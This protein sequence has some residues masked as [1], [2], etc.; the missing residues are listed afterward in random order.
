[1]VDGLDVLRDRERLR[2]G[3]TSLRQR[4]LAELRE[5]AS[6]TSLASRLGETRQRVN[7]HLRELEKSGLVELVE[8]RQRRGRQERLLR[9][10]ARTVVVAPTVVGPPEPGA[11][12]RF[13]VETLLTTAARTCTEVADLRERAAAAG[14]R[15]IT[16]TI[17]AEIGFAQPAEI[18][19]FVGRIGERIAELA[20]EYDSPTAPRR[21]RLT[22][23]GHPS[24]PRPGGLQPPDPHKPDPHKPDPQGPDPQEQDRA[25]KEDW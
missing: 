20:G 2:G 24:V 21:Y 19:E 15:L 6:A 4:L 18:E 8:V 12:D 13:A 1:M 23:T 10:T 5:P 3:L 17:E 14:K 7:Y 25:A 9:A 11:Q 16:F 22:V